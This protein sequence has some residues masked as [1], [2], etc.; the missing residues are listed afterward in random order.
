MLFETFHSKRSEWTNDFERK[1]IIDW[2]THCMHM[3]FF[4]RSFSLTLFRSHCL[5]FSSFL[6]RRR[7]RGKEED[8][9]LYD[10]QFKTQTIIAQEWIFI[11]IHKQD[12]GELEL[13]LEK[14]FCSHSFL[15]PCAR[16]SSYGKVSHFNIISVC[17]FSIQEMVQV[18]SVHSSVRFG[19]V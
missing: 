9:Y 11:Q 18:F 8:P 17:R 2:N 15:R 19:S 16:I 10:F 1:K 4:L 5:P 12:A 6:R 3:I 13:R 14:K 7:R